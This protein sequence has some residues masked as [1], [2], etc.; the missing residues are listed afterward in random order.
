[1]DCGADVGTVVGVGDVS[2][3]G[4]ASV[5]VG[6]VD[7]RGVLVG[8]VAVSVWL[9]PGTGEGKVGVQAAATITR[10]M[11]RASRITLL[12]MR[13]SSGLKVG[14]NRKIAIGAV[15]SAFPIFD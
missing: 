12:L 9:G 2:S 3:V 14:S 1:M 6:D 10:R 8:M 7:D 15:Y 4:T 13:I 11:Q 5:A